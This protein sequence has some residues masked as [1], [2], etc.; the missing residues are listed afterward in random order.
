MSLV[1]DVENRV[2]EV[3]QFLGSLRE[4]REPQDVAQQ[5]ALGS[6]GG[7]R[8]PASMRRRFPTGCCLQNVVEALFVLGWQ[9][10]PIHVGELLDP[11]RI[12]QN[13]F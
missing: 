12:L 4:A 11:L 3:G 6:A 9:R 7:G 2:G 5:D 1:A 10:G 8:A 13:L